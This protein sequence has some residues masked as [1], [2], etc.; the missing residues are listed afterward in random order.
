MA[1]QIG[2]YKRPGIF[3]E[4]I[5]RSVVTSPT[6]DLG[7]PN[8]VIGVSRKGPVNT[9]IEVKNISEITSIFGDIDRQLEKKGSFF[10]RTLQ[11]MIES[12][13]VYA[14]NLLLTDD[15]LDTVEYM[16]LS[17]SSQYTNGTKKTAPFRRFFDTTG[18]WKRSTGEFI[19]ITKEN[20][21]Y[22]KRVLN[23]TNLGDKYIS[24]FCF[25]SQRTGFDRPMLEWY[26]SVE[27]MPPYVYP[28]D[29]ASDY[30]VDVLVVGGDWSD[31][32]ALGNDPRWNRYFNSEGLIKT[33]VR[34]FT[35]DRNVSVLAF[36]EGL[37][38]I[39]YFRDLDGR[40]IFIE[41][42]INRDTDK[43]GLFCA[44][45]DDIFESNYPTGL[46]DL[47]GNSLVG[48]DLMNNPPTID[49]TYFQTL[50]S[51][52]SV[53][54][55][56]LSINFL[57]YKEKL[58]ETLA[59]PNVALDRPGNVS[60][61]FTQDPAFDHAFNDGS[62]V[63]GVFDLDSRVYNEERTYWFSEGYV[64]QFT[65]LGLTSSS[66]QVTFNFL[67]ATNSY[68]VINGNLITLS[69][70]YS[71]EV[72]NTSY[73]AATASATYSVAIVL[74]T[75]GSVKAVTTKTPSTNP[76]V[77]ASDIVLGIGEFGISGGVMSGFSYTDVTIDGS[78]YVHLTQG[79]QSTDG[80]TIAT[81]STT[82]GAIVVSFPN[83]NSTPNTS[84]YVTY[85]KF[86]LFNSILSYINTSSS[87]RGLML[88]EPE[89]NT[90]KKTLSGV[91]ISDVKTSTTTN[92]GFT[93]QTGLQY[94]DLVDIVDGNYTLVFYKRDDEFIVSY[95]G[96]ETKDTIADLTSPATE[97]SLGVVG[98]YSNFYGDYVAGK[99]NTTD[100]VYQNTI[101]DSA[102]VSF[103]EGS[104]VQDYLEGYNYL[105]FGVDSS[106]SA[107]AE[108]D[109]Y[110]NQIETDMGSDMFY[111]FLIGAVSNSGVF[112]VRI[113]QGLDTTNLAYVDAVGINNITVP[114][115]P[116]DRAEILGYTASGGMRYFAFEV[117][118]TVTDEVFGISK[119]FGYNSE[120]ADQ[121]I[122]LQMYLDSDDRLFVRY[123][124]YK[125]ASGGT[126]S[127]VFLSS[128]YSGIDG[129]DAN[130]TLFVKS[131]K[132]DFKQSIE[133]EYPSGWEPIP[134]KILVKK[135]RY[136][137]IKVGDYLEAQY[138]V[139]LL[140]P[141]QM[142]KKLTRIT[143]KKLWSVDTSYVEISCDAPI[144]LYSFP[145]DTAPSGFD[146]QTIRRTSLDDYATTYKAIPL[147]GFRVRNESLPDGTDSRQNE[148]LNVVAP[149]TALFGALTNKDAFD[150][151]YLVDSFGLG[152]TEDS[153]QN[154]VDICGARL[155]CFGIL[156]MP[157]LRQFKN[158]VSPNFKDESGVL[159]MEFV[160]KGGDPESN[161]DF[162]YSFGKGPGVTT[163]GYFLPYVVIDDFGRQLEVPPAAYVA[164]TFMRK[165]NQSLS[166]IT[167]WTVAAG[168]NNGR[169]LGI[170]DIEQIF[171]PTDLEFLNQAQMNPITFKRNRGFIIETDNTA[172][173]LVKSSLSEI[174]VREVLI[175]LERELSTMLLDFQWK[176]NTPETRSA[177]KLA[178]DVICEKYVAGG[179]L[180]NYFNKIDDE[181][182]PLEIVD[183]GIGVLDTYVEPIKAMGIIVNN[184]TILRTGAIQ[185]GGFII[186]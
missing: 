46:V 72:K 127:D 144:K 145:S 125:L 24:V 147:K 149:G 111:Q 75:Q 56:E 151:R 59:Y 14:V 49:E 106:S 103:V 114:S 167:P 129:L 44:F 94:S 61:L 10:H 68:A 126:A 113:D 15:E 42:V 65:Y 155:D 5:D 31:A 91:V 153:K 150:F 19:S 95:A 172:Q 32:E 48:D 105:I 52:D 179:G 81:S 71:V 110:F 143:Q 28:T 112:T 173:V 165:F 89:T 40:N 137:R 33:R 35:S 36:Y 74:D 47:V 123:K 130:T 142:P 39:P 164:T 168:V 25:K 108:F 138:D 66:S 69:G 109:G 8:L 98:R 23:F 38:M 156:N 60:G 85:R 54:D 159:S 119:L 116:E 67:A 180:F 175:E 18:F 171:A 101:L 9:P 117:N 80:Y 124:D 135:D 41:S 17:G 50:D 140:Q 182:N 58:T 141:D 79:T 104:T 183:A 96:F 146:R 83:T 64:N 133:A 154:L 186:S 11:K 13:P 63:G 53:T 62:V 6:Q 29:L 181:N 107:I 174:H 184:I 131:K 43:T 1:I 90:V 170:N 100:V 128:I 160:A 86:K 21:G 22:E 26:G 45:N 34:E 20:S 51:N 148:I 77:S 177:I 3:I 82:E 176:A 157:S 87:F 70:T 121:P 4:E 163:V 76:T 93:I 27:K 78:G 84:D 120:F 115:S 55:G 102:T 37:S 132:G 88:L 97:T 122:Y 169:V 99:T 2:K 12:S 139:T 92:K 136:G 185:A 73:S 178:A 152:L 118:E 161:P 30:L 134:N 166:T 7:T 158:S 57:S 162:L 16:P